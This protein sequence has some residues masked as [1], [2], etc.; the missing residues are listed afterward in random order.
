MAVLT[1]QKMSDG[2]R[3]GL[4]SLE[5]ASIGVAVPVGPKQIRRAKALPATDRDLLALRPRDLAGAQSSSSR[6]IGPQRLC[7]RGEAA[8]QMWSTARLDREEDECR[9]RV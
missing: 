1:W 9:I 4:I 8:A 7:F 5:F 6:L 2:E 3:I